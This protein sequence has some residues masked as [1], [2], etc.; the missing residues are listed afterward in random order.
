MSIVKTTVRAGAAKQNP[1][2]I[3]VIANPVLEASWQ[4]GQFVVD[5]I[6]GQLTTFQAAVS[7]IDDALFGQLAGQR[8]KV[9]AD[10]AMA[11]NEA[12]QPAFS[13]WQKMTCFCHCCHRFRVLASCHE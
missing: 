8:E 11:G 10:P 4:S 1:F 2:T 12:L 7:Y 3:C 5:P 6:I 13:R 9:L